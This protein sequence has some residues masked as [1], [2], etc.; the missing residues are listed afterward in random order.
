MTSR[1]LIPVWFLVIGFVAMCFPAPTVPAACLLLAVTVLVPATLA[2][3][4][5][6][7][8]LQP[9]SIAAQTHR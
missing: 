3:G 4:S 1:M 6:R 9:L 5:P 7:R 2:F 8:F